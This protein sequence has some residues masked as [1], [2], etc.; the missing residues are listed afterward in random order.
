M[1]ATVG[2]IKTFQSVHRL[3]KSEEGVHSPKEMAQTGRHD[4]PG[5]S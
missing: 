2:R 5:A 3:H 4:M 1:C